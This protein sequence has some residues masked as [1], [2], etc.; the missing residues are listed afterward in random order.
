[1]SFFKA[2]WRG[3]SKHKKLYDEKAFAN[4][5]EWEPVTEP[6]LEEV[7]FQV[8]YLGSTLVEKPSSEEA[9]AEAVKTVMTMAKAS[10]KKLQR[11]ILS[12]SLNGIKMIDIPTEETHLEVSIYRI[13]YCSADA[14]HG[15]V[16]AFIATNANELMECHAFLCPR[17]KTAQTMSLTVAQSFRTAYNLWSLSQERIALTDND[18]KDTDF[19]NNYIQDEM[20]HN[21][22]ELESKTLLIDFNTEPNQNRLSA[23][24]RFE[25]DIT[26]NLNYT[27]LCDNDQKL[28]VMRSTTNHIQNFFGGNN[29]NSNRWEDSRANL[30][31]S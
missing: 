17:R 30:L 4:T 15:Q 27:R 7:T 16:F 18:K 25:E 2:I 31:C 9:T 24:E 19:H 11:V 26:D 22:K 28:P 29:I 20:Q 8:K 3:N 13:S 14:A 6:P 1:M 21:P 5:N 23:W 10:G 12:V